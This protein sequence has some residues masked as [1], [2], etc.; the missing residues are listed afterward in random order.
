MSQ[1]NTDKKPLT[2]EEIE[3]AKKADSTKQKLVSN[4]QTVKK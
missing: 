2:K 4:N 1:T 3:A